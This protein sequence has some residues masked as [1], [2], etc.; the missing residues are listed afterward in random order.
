VREGLRLHRALLRAEAHGAAKVGLSVAALDLPGAVE[1]LADQR[2]HRMRRLGV[3]LG[4]VGAFEAADVPRE[5]DGSEL[6]A[7]ADAEVGH[8]VFARIADG[9]HL[10]L[11][12]ALAEAAGHQ[13]RIHL[14]ERGDRPEMMK[15]DI[16][17]RASPIVA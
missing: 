4:A 9:G 17:S 7:Q 11:G 14:L 10:A 5:L 16:S 15:C 6:H 2:H 1:P 13:D 8:A 12:A 3:E